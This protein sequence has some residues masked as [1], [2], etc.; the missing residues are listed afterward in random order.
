MFSLIII[1]FTAT[2]ACIVDEINCNPK[3]LWKA[4]EYRPDVFD[5]EKMK[6][7]LINL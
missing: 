5:V 3:S 1:L 7:T 6:K 4:A 2:L